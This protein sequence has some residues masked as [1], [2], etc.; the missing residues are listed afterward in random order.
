VAPDRLEATRAAASSAGLAMP[1]RPFPT[2][3]PPRWA[4]VVLLTGVGGLAV[5]GCALAALARSLVPDLAVN[6]VDADVTGY[7]VAN[8]V[9]G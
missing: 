9:P 8:L 1:M 4:A 5:V 3:V 7:L 6:G 2:S